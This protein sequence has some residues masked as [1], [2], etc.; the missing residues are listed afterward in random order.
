MSPDP[1]SSA[2]LLDPQTWN[3]YAYVGNNPLAYVDPTGQEKKYFGSVIKRTWTSS[4]S[5]HT[6]DPAQMLVATVPASTEPYSSM[7]ARTMNDPRPVGKGRNPITW[8]NTQD[9]SPV[10]ATEVEIRFKDTTAWHLSFDIKDDGSV[11]FQAEQV[12]M[13]GPLESALTTSFHAWEPSPTSF[14]WK[15]DL[16]GLSDKELQTLQL[17][18]LSTATEA[19]QFV[20]PYNWFFRL[21]RALSDAINEEQRQRKETQNKQKQ[22]KQ[23]K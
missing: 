2:T 3:K 4:V 16:K 20:G 6:V 5:S 9:D 12:P 10:S 8:T 23:E 14:D 15:F 13:I 18:V 17:A 11:I 7:P 21:F 22:K 19:R 1:V